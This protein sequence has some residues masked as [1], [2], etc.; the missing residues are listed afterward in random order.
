MAPPPPLPGADSA[1]VL[2]YCTWWWAWPTVLRAR[3]KAN[4]GAAGD[5]GVLQ[6]DE[7]PMHPARHHSEQTWRDIEPLWNEQLAKAAADPTYQPSILRLLIARNRGRVYVAGALAAISGL[8]SSAVKPILLSYVID[9]AQ[10]GRTVG[11]AA[12]LV[13]TLCAVILLEGWAQIFSR[14]MVMW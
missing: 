9:A 7:L 2:S 13:L 3:A 11:E 1:N 8:C 14:G 10:E 6:L 4:S 5:D 12:P